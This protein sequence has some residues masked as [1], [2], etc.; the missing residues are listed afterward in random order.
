MILQRYKLSGL[1]SEMPPI[2][3]CFECESPSLR[4]YFEG[5]G[6]FRRWLQPG[7]VGHWGQ[8]LAPSSMS[9]QLPLTKVFSTMDRAILHASLLW[10]TAILLKP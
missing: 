4:Y 5:Y 1:E 8:A 2:G 6:A 10:V 7:E 3:L 9:C